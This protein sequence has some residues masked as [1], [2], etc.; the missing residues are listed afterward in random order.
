MKYND[1]K[2]AGP[3]ALICTLIALL[4]NNDP[5]RSQDSCAQAQLQS[6]ATSTSVSKGGVP[7]GWTNT[8]GGTIPL[9]LKEEDDDNE[10]VTWQDIYGNSHFATYTATTVTT[11]DA[12]GTVISITCSGS[13]TWDEGYDDQ[14]T[15]SID[16]S[17]CFWDPDYGCADGVVGSVGG[18]LTT[19]PDATETI[20]TTDNSYEDTWEGCG[21]Y[22][23]YKETLSA[24]NTD[25]AFQNYIASNLPPYPCDAEDA[26]ASSAMSADTQTGG[27][28]LDEGGSVAF[29]SWGNGTH[30]S[31]SGGK[32]KYAFYVTGTQLNMTYKVSWHE[33]T[34]YPD[35]T[36][37]SCLRSEEIAGNGNPSM[38][39]YTS[40]RE[41]QMPLVECTIGEVFDSVKVVSNGAAGN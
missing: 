29:W 11:Y 3:S 5:A 6:C 22:S 30:S 12:I 16:P 1:L 39:V 36:A 17:T 18:V 15:D 4:M 24:E 9:Y 8:G 27:S 35:G 28:G 23:D 34:S 26:V 31:A 37:T 13:A 33:V 41:V 7:A 14:C 20:N 2:R 10:H 32:M 40:T 25:E 38:G 19:C 21:A